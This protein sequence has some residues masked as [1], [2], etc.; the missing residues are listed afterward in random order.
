MADGST[1]TLF[2]NQTGNVVNMKVGNTRSS[3]PIASIAGGEQFR[4]PVNMNDTYREFLVGVGS[5]TGNLKTVIVT[6][7]DCCDYQCITIKEIADGTIDLLREPR[8]Q[9]QQTD[10]TNSV[11]LD[12]MTS[13]PAAK[14]P[15]FAWRMCV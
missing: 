2:V 5:D 10:G 4:M 3:A 9:Q 12:Q 1:S 15:W 13:S 6:S 11:K 8:R 14:R 7:D